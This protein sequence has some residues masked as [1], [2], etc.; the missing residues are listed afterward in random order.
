[1][2]NQISKNTVLQFKHQVVRDLA[3][4]LW[5]PALLIHEKPYNESCNQEDY[6]AIDEIWLKQLD[7][8]PKPLLEY[9]KSK[10]S[11]LLGTYFEALWQFYFSHHSSF[12]QCICN[13]QINDK[14][15]TVGEFDILVTNSNDQNFHIELTCK[16]YLE[17]Q[18]SLNNTLWLGPNCGDRL[19]FKYHKTQ[20]HQLPLLN[21][22][23]GKLNYQQNSINSNAVRQM[24]IW[25]GTFFPKNRW[26][27]EDQL[28]LLPKTLSQNEA[29]LWCFADK[30]YWLSPLIQERKNLKTFKQIKHDINNNFSVGDSFIGSND[31]KKHTALMLIALS[32]NEDNKQWQ[33]QEAFFITPSVWPYGKFSD[34]AS[35][36]LRPCRPPL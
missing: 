15:R 4:S 9:I 13:L 19:D 11:R 20:T 6:F 35:T 26:F 27:K 24:G 23:I 29:F 22:E 2:H 34:S 1:M 8:Q 21:T 16:F 36:P 7:D 12:K 30:K 10:N 33:Q 17:W 18:D 31:N 32:F 3:W 5:G 28:D 14:N 25:R